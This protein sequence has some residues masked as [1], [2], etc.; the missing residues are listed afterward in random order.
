MSTV[1]R[2]GS[3]VLALLVGLLPML[4]AEHVHESD[5]DGHHEALAHRHFEEHLPGQRPHHDTPDAAVVDHDDEHTVT[6]EAAYTTHAAFAFAVPPAI[7][8]AFLDA[9]PMPVR[10]GF[11][12]A[13]ER[14]SHGPPRAP[15]SL[16]A[17]PRTSLL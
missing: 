8:V 11:M 5:H 2:P 9:P 1:T 15:A 7:L 3:L 14:L 12:P 6:L 10:H 17:P 13:V 4:P 16:R